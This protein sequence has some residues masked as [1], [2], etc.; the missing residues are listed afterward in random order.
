MKKVLIVSLGMEIGGA[1]RSLITMLSE[2]DYSKVEIDLFLLH[3]R[4]DLLKYVPKEV[5]L[6]E[7]NE[8]YS[9]LSIP[10]KTVIKNRKIGVAYGR[11]QAK[12][13]AK[14]YNMLHCT[15]VSHTSN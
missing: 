1:E 7:E 3:K 5:N 14:L 8:Y 10:F 12:I 2:L 15:R 11:L 4:G 6:L 13:S 9:Q